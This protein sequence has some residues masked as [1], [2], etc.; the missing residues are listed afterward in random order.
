MCIAVNLKIMCEMKEGFHIV[1]LANLLKEDHE[2]S[3]I[4]A[5]TL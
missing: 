2:S 1:R 3:A 4:M 5:P